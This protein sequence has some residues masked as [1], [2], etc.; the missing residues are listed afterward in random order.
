MRRLLLPLLVLIATSASAADID[1]VRQNYIG[2]Y[3]GAGADV[4]APRM[5]DALAS[6]ETEARNDTRAGFLLSNGSW[7]DLNYSE[8]PS[9]TWSPWEH[10]KRLIVMAKAYR[11]PGQDLYRDPT[12]RAEI[13]SALSYTSVYYG[14]T[15]FPNGNW[16]FWTIGV[17]LDL[18]PTLVLMR[19]DI[20][21]TVYNNCVQAM[22]LRIGSSPV[23]RGIVGPVPVGENLAW[24]CFTHLTLALLKDDASMLAPVRD[25]MANVTIASASAEGIKPDLSFQQHGAQL[26]TGGYGGSFA[27]DVAQ[28]TLLTRGTGYALP[29]ASLASFNDYLADGVIW[30]LYGNYFDVSVI[31]REVARPSTSGFNGLAA[32]LQGSTVVSPRQ[33][34]IESAAAKML[35]T[36]GG[37]PIELAG[38]A[39][40]IEQSGITAAWPSG[41]RHYWMSDYAVHR[42][43]G[44]FASIKMFSTRTKSGENTNEENLLGSRQADGRLY[45][46]RDGDTYYTHDV[47][48]A[49]DWTRLPGITVEQNGN[50]ANDTYG[51]G[52]NRFAGGVSDGSN[53]IA[54]MQLAPLGS[55]MTANKSWF[56]FDDALVCL[57][58][59]ITSVSPDH[60][61][62]IVNQWPVRDASSQLLVDGSPSATRWALLDGIGYFFPTPAP[63]LTKRETRSGSWAALGGSTDTTPHSADVVTL[64][65]DHGAAPV[66]ASTAYVVAPNATADMLRSWS[67]NPPVSV[68]ANSSDVAAVRDLRTDALG[69]VFFDTYGS[70]NGY[71]ADAPA[72]VYAV[73]NGSALLLHVADPMANSTGVLHVT[74]PGLWSTSDAK[75][76]TATARA[77][78]IEIP[79]NSGQTAHVT[80]TPPL[81][82]RRAVRAGS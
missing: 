42:R 57:A 10:T 12:L 51:Y 61:E 44:W 70:V 17:P 40:N 2:Y 11:T 37:L 67:A 26:Y 8:T 63:L 25:A 71:S 79:R 5:H 6:L 15:S 1:L 30:S 78:T 45:L 75:I 20:D 82:R 76:V 34:E 21:P 60:S 31:S 65:I 47:W 9:G 72:I 18:G 19:G 27:N 29:P 28:Y 23:S 41:H 33:H 59:A 55:H 80:L 13:E 62:T 39:T 38:L 54:A 66:D 24:S 77:T 3:T 81:G 4:T 52:S 22:Y 69:I 48:P 43:D 50:A 74:V 14:M 49:L 58:G 35:Q 68:L 32:L 36:W 56:F 7:S 64:W 73:P 16:W 53:G 46:V